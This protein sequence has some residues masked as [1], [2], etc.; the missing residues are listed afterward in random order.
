[1]TR[2]RTIAPFVTL[3][4]L[5][6]SCS[7]VQ[8]RRDPLC[9]HLL[10][11]ANSASI[12]TQPAIELVSDWSSFSKHCTHGGTLAGRQF[13]DWLLPNTST[14]FAT[15]NIQ[16]TLACLAPGTNYAGSERL[17]PEYVTGKVQSLNV[18]G[19]DADVVITVEYAVGIEGERPRMKIQAERL[20]PQD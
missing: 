15:I 6:T 17:F 1:M 5:A 9:A 19:L 10:A 7:T 13:C 8:A 16:R 18:R 2:L 4:L 11:F 3:A 14:E 20:P 12:G